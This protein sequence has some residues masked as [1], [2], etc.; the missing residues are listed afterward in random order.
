MSRTDSKIPNK[1]KILNILID[2]ITL[3]ELLIKCDKGIVVT[4]NVDHL[5]HLQSDK[6]FYNL[7]QKADF[8]INDSQIIKYASSFLKDPLKE[9]ISGADFFP[10]FCS[11]HATNDNIKIFLL[12]AK[13]GVS[14]VAK[15]K[16]NTK[17]NRKLIVDNYSPSIGFEKNDIECIDIVNKINNSEANVLVIGV[18]APKQEKWLLKYHDRFSK[19]KIFMLLGATIDFEAGIIKRSPKWMSSLGLE[20]LFR[21]TQDPFRLWKR[22]LINDTPFFWLVLKQKFG[23]YKNPF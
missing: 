8:V 23:L 17:Y 18:G 13:R 3:D 12:G 2:N 21:I 19:I 1:V 14:T 6:L 7:Y 20:W 22:Y 4:P 10:A 16:I 11:Y 9:K 15:N 5:I